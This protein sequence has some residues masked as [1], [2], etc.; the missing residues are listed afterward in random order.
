[1]LCPVHSLYNPN[2]GQHVYTGKASEIS[3]LESNGWTDEGVK[4]YAF[5]DIDNR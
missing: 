1:M 5:L 3:D 2:N 4:F